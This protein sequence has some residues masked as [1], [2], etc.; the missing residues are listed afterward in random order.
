M[1][2]LFRKELREEYDDGEVGG[3]SIIARKEDCDLI[4]C[5]RVVQD[6]MLRRQP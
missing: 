5:Y 2:S 3:V 1:G 4:D 6:N